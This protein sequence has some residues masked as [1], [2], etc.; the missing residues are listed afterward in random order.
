MPKPSITF[1]CELETPD[2]KVLFSDSK[3]MKD[4]SS[5]NANV[6]LGLLDLSMER[7]DIVKK[8]TRAGIPITAWLLL[9]KS[10][11][12]WTNLDTI[13]DAIRQYFKFKEWR[14]KHKLE[15]SVI[16]LDIEPKLDT[17]L[18]LGKNPVSQFKQIARRYFSGKRYASNEVD[19]RALMQMIRSDGFAVET[20]Q[21][22]IVVDE[23]AARSNFFTKIL[24]ILPLPSDREVLML[25]SSFFPYYADSILWSYAQHA[26]AVG[27]G[28][29]GGGVELEGLPPLKVLRWIDL[30][31]D[32]LLASQ[33][34]N[35]LYIF[36]LEGCIKNNYMD[37]FIELDWSTQVIPPTRTAMGVSLV[38]RVGQVVL[39]LL[40]HPFEAL[41]WILV[42]TL[43]FNRIKKI[44]KK[45]FPKT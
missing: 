40:S 8:L 1:F 44:G 32:L 41:A 5:L 42:G 11:G 45:E 2:L 34:V 4:L 20:Y 16:G 21:F 9:P 17:V 35:H 23:R 10:E 28:S 38:R 26:K 12:Y 30:K 39:C 18:A 3:V 24:G 22:P 36:S 43:I 7:A 33:A 25:Y 31:R 14:N 27:I 13:Q 29:T 19:T 6:S 37:R 15:I